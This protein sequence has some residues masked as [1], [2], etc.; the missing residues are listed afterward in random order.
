MLLS[1]RG[2]FSGEFTS[3]SQKIGCDWGKVTSYF[4]AAANTIALQLIPRDLRKHLLF[5]NGSALPTPHLTP[6]KSLRRTAG[7]V[8]Q[9]ITAKLNRWSFHLLNYSEPKKKSKMPA[10]CG[11]LTVFRAWKPPKPVRENK[12]YPY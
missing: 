6:G 11:G 8:G 12:M 2:C 3:R 1:L 10:I 5:W 7:R 4:K 9:H